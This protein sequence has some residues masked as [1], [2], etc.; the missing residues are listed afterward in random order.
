[1]HKILHFVFYASF[2]I[3]CGC[4]V[5]K[6][7]TNQVAY[8]QD[9]TQYRLHFEP[10]KEEITNNTL[11]EN[12]IQKGSDIPRNAETEQINDLI[13]Q[14]SEPYEEITKTNGYRIQFYSGLS[15]DDAQEMQKQ[16]RI[17]LYNFKDKVF[18]LYTQPYYKV[19][20]GNY[21]SRLEAYSVVKEVQKEF[22][23]ANVISDV[24][25]LRSLRK[26]YKNQDDDDNDDE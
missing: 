8:S 3:L 26:K 17:K 23:S 24:I 13:D 15:L 19:K 16:A 25:S 7:I 22:S 4:K 2:G 5:Q 10:I 12:L 18:I 20:M 21:V 14:L 11:S 6:P 9:L 1:M